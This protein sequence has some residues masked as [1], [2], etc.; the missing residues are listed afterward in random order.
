VV[1]GYEAAMELECDALRL[2]PGHYATAYQFSLVHLL[3]QVQAFGG[4]CPDLFSK[5]CQ[6]PPKVSGG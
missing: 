6:L 3:A 4:S 2:T 5:Q 1:N